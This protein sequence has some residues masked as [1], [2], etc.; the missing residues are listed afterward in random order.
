M[1]TDRLHLAEA[2][3]LRQYPEG[4]ASADLAKIGKRHRIEQM[5]TLARESL[6]KKSFAHQAVVLDAIVRLVTRSSMVSLFEKPKFRDAINGLDKDDRAYLADGFRLLLHGNEEKG[7]NRILDVLSEI[8]LAKWSLITIVP[9]YYRPQVD[10]FVKPTTTK[11]IIRFLELEGLDY[12][13]RPSWDFYA[14]YREAIN[15]CKAQVNPSLAVNNAAFTGFLMMTLDR[16]RA[17]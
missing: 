10:V 13:P 2:E 6:T 8:R 9:F 16:G 3:F 14:R 4:F 5:T 12:R 15:A 17:E 11:N 7:F 1:R